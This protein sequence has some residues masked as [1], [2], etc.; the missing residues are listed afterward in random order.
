MSESPLP[1][2]GLAL[3]A[4]VE[5]QAV[6]DFARRHDLIAVRTVQA[7]GRVPFQQHWCT[8]DRQ[9]AVAYVDDRFFQV[10]YLHV[11]G[12]SALALIRDARASLKKTT[13]LEDLARM[14]NE[15]TSQIETM[16]AVILAGF[17]A[18]QHDG[19]IEAL[20]RRG[21]AL[22]DENARRDTLLAMSYAGWV[23]LRELFR[24]CETRE[25]VPELRQLALRLR[26]SLEEKR[27]KHG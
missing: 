20:F 22:E 11:R 6:L 7:A 5:P 21:L 4:T 25:P 18:R 3:D 16:V 19:R 23:E 24:E 26:A 1:D 12:P 9:T 10:H 13:D 2:L 8:A 17:V 27:W 14:A 15:A